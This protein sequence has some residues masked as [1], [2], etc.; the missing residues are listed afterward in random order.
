[1]MILYF[2]IGC[3]IVM[4]LIFLAA[5]FW[6]LKDGQQDDMVTPGIRVLF[7]DDSPKVAETES[8]EVGKSGRREVRKSESP[9]V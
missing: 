1:M 3:S 6:S 9:K 2:L 7:D 5:F 4:A 8:R